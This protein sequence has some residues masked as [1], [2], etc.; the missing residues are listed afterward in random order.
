LR[1]VTLIHGSAQNASGWA[2][3]APLLHGDVRVLELPKNEPSWTLRDYAAF[4]GPC[5]VAVAHS[6]SGAF[7]PLI[8]C[9]VRVFLG[10]LIPEPRTSVRDQLVADPT[11][12]PPDWIATGVRWRDH[13]EEREALAREFLF[14]DCDAAILPWAYTTVDAMSTNALAVEPSPFDT[15]PPGRDVVIIPTADRTI[16]PEWMRKRARAIDA[17]IVEI[18]AGHCPHVSRA[19]E[20]A[21]V[22]IGLVG[23]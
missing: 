4:I 3:L 11:M 20:V 17:D 5:D 22:L 10:A 7:L 16:S 2:R 9:N 19:G 6:F 12:L 8:D 18:E 1:S 21:E 14:H 13:P 15:W 23:R